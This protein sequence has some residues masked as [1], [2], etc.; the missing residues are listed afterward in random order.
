MQIHQI[1]D[2]RSFAGKLFVVNKLSKK[3]ALCILKEKSNLLELI[4]KE[5][6]D[7]YIKQD[8]SKNKVDIIATAR[9]EPQ[10]SIT[11]EVPL[12]AKHSSYLDATKQ[13]IIR[14]KKAKE[15]YVFDVYEKKRTFQE[16]LF[17]VINKFLIEYGDP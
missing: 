13:S 7:L 17:D 15:E 1:S 10:I 9:T 8:Y 3:P 11:S 6:F 12:T 5:K 16:K 2:N 4:K 14:Y